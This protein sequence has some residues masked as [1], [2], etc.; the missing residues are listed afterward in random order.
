[1]CAFATGNLRR[2]G[3]RR[4]KLFV[5]LVRFLFLMNVIVR[6][7]QQDLQSHCP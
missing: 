6:V 1:M 5:I 2:S 7:A 3:L 4:K